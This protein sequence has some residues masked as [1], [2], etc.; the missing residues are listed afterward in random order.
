MINEHDIADMKPER[1]KSK[2][3]VGWCVQVFNG[4]WFNAGFPTPDRNQAA[5][6]LEWFKEMWPHLEYRVYEEVK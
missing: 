5:K 4:E 2:N 1:V 3:H 6:E